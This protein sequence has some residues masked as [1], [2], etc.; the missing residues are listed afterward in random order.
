VAKNKK[1]NGGMVRVGP[2][3]N[4]FLLCLFIG[5]S[6]I[7]YVWQKNQIHKLGRQISERKGRL[8]EL[9]RQNKMRADHL[10]ALASPAALDSKARAL[11]LGLT[12]PPISQVVRLIEAPTEPAPAALREY[13]EHRKAEA[14]P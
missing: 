10:A 7:G 1:L 9:R 6:G 2:A 14:M 3:V 13:A 12:Q 8:A 11:N 4:A 5:G